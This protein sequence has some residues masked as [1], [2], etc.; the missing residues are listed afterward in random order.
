MATRKTKT[1]EF[2]G[3][4]EDGLL[5][6]PEKIAASTLMLSIGDD[7]EIPVVFSTGGACDFEP[8]DGVEIVFLGVYIR[9]S[10]PGPQNYQWMPALKS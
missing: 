3:G 8:G 6:E 10:G 9:E 5:V 1:A 2:I 7:D 4:P